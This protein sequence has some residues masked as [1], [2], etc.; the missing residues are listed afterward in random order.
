M[1]LFRSPAHTD[2]ASRGR[3][4]ARPV[5]TRNVA[6]D[7]RQMR[8]EIQSS[9]AKEASIKRTFDDGARQLVASG[10]YHPRVLERL[11]DAKLTPV[12]DDRDDDP[13]LG[14]ANGYV[15]TYG[16]Y[17]SLRS[18]DNKHVAFHEEAHRVFRM[19]KSVT[20]VDTRGHEQVVYAY[21]LSLFNEVAAERLARDVIG[22]TNTPDDTPPAY[23][24]HDAVL[25]KTLLIGKTSFY[26]FGRIAT[27][28]NPETN[29][30]AFRTVVWDRAGWDVVG[31]VQSEYESEIT[32]NNFSV[33]SNYRAAARINQTLSQYV[34][35][36]SSY[37]KAA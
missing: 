10:T 35:E 20:Q 32:A 5:S 23:Q 1:Q 25:T 28:D 19:A 37:D 22:I 17:I 36:T 13:I 9:A 8:V 26:E 12:W 29:Y 3:H 30:E 7:W 18:L 24:P 14:V 21:G 33:E 4:R 15:D 27:G 2:H 6:E 16:R 11:P 34:P 31:F